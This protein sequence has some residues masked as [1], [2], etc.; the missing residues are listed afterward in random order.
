MSYHAA[1][2]GYT[3]VGDRLVH[4]VT[5]GSGP[6]AVLLHASPADART[7][8]WLVDTLG[9]D[10][11]VLALDT[12]GHGLS[13]PLGR[14]EPEID[15]YGA[16][17]VG[18]LDALGLDRVHLY[19]THTGAKIALSAA[20][21]DPGRVASLTLDGL[22]ISTPDERADQLD[23]YTVTWPP[24]PD[25]SHLVQAWHQARNMFL[26]WP[27]YA[28]HPGCLLRDAMPTP[29][30]LHTIA[31]GMLAA[32]ERYP[33]A[34]R[35]AFRYDP[36]PALARLAVPTT[37]VAAPDDPLRA[38]LGRLAPLP[39]V[40]RVDGAATGAAARG[41]VVE[42][43]IRAYP[44]AADRDAGHLPYTPG[45]RRFVPTALGD[46]HVSIAAGP[47]PREVVIAPLGARLDPPDGSRRLVLEVPGT[48]R[49]P[50][51]AAAE[52]ALDDL[53]DCLAQACAATGAR[54][55]TVRATAS[56]AGV[57]VALARRLGAAVEPC[58]PGA[59]LGPADLPDLRP[60]ADGA[61]LLAAWHFVRD[62][63][64]RDVA[65]HGRWPGAH[66]DAPDLQLLDDRAIGLAGSW[67]ALP[68]VYAAC[69]A[70]A[71]SGPP[72]SWDPFACAPTDGGRT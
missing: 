63:A 52:P 4:Y 40:V 36:V 70:A 22:G 20:L 13:D 29:G 61:H 25:G 49:S 17:L 66:G 38:H 27:W 67:R 45:A 24:R 53:A 44:G 55:S 37:I 48:G 21:R 64:L 6:V 11:C 3:A 28:E 16:S 65:A 72:G 71:A 43:Q 58:G 46:V 19:G 47:P 15:D 14:P 41:G 69:A 31:H 2:H 34:Y 56:T 5:R 62:A 9:D 33:L 26:F 60:R 8:S 18:S 51:V 68:G 1:R 35:A 59:R 32:G 39:S 10:C 50:E 7:L 23:R 42:R 12:P 57:A 30:E 54:P